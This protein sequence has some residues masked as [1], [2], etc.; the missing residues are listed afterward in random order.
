MN[1]VKTYK[2]GDRFIL[3]VENCKGSLA[4]KVNEFIVSIMGIE[5]EPT[6]VP[7]IP[8]EVEEEDVP[9]ISS[10][11]EIL[12]FVNSEKQIDTDVF[13]FVDGLYKGM[14]YEEAEKQDGAKAVAYTFAHAKEVAPNCVEQI[15]EKCK[16]RLFVDCGLGK[17]DPD[18]D[19]ENDFRNFIDTYDSILNKTFK[20][21]SAQAG[22]ENIQVMI[23]SARENLWRDG[24][25]AAKKKLL[26]IINS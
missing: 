2:D 19:S 10:C 20:S 25:A 3:V 24:Y 17:Y 23:D 18:L 6:E 9:D 4:T 7:L 16:E 26:E 15:K 5:E 12:Q 21:I 1:N 14:T 8:L 11:E 13:R 22:Y